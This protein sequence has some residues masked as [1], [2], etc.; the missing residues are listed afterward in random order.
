[1]Y[2]WASTTLHSAIVQLLDYGISVLIIKYSS[3]AFA[4]CSG[5]SVMMYNGQMQPSL[6]I[7]IE[8]LNCHWLPFWDIMVPDIHVYQ[9]IPVATKVDVLL[10]GWRGWDAFI[11]RVVCHLDDLCRRRRRRWWKGRKLV[12]LKPVLLC[13][14]SR[15][16]KWNR[17][18]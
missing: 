6:H 14:F 10:I 1:M 2:Q 12:A 3:S 17:P 5:S 7:V 9:D 18:Q 8:A 15:I 4:A 13:C 16:R 11:H